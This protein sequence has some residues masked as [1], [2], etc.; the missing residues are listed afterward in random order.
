DREKGNTAEA[1]SELEEAVRIAPDFFQARNDLGK[2]YR[3]AGRLDDA[4]REF[5]SAERLNEKSAEPLIQLSGLY[6][7]RNQPELAV[8]AGEEAVKKD[9]HSASAYYN[10]G[11]AFYRVS[12]LDAA[13]NALKKALALAPTAGQIHLLLANVYLKQQDWNQLRSQLDSYLA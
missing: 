5:L 1:T 13:E 9:S 2:A 10:L 4:E 7:D 12:R 6:I 8:K 11:F 3:T